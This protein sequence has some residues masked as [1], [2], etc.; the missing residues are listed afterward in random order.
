MQFNEREQSVEVKNVETVLQHEGGYMTK[1]EVG[2]G[3]TESG[4]CW[5]AETEV[6]KLS[7]EAR[8]KAAYQC[9]VP[10]CNINPRLCLLRPCNW[11]DSILW[12][13][14]QA[15]GSRIVACV[16]VTICMSASECG[17][18]QTKTNGEW[19]HYAALCSWC[20]ADSD[21]DAMYCHS[22]LPRIFAN[23]SMN[24]K[25]TPETEAIRQSP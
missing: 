20:S 3:C 18:T 16:A 7:T 19:A 22:S 13:E 15:L 12:C 6:R 10:Y 25:A 24:S 23:G 21:T 5:N 1:Q 2:P 8:R 17:Q 4:K 9:L 11:T 14:S